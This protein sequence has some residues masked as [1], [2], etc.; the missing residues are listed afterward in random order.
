MR[1]LGFALLVCFPGALHAQS[2]AQPCRAPTL[3]GGYFVPRQEM[4]S[5]KTKLTYAC[6]TGR[7]PVVEGWWVT[8][9]CDNG[10]WSHLPQCIDENACIPPTI[11][12]GKYTESSDG[13]YEN[14]DIIRITCDKG[15]EHKDNDATGICTN[16]NWSSLPIC[17]RSMDACSEPPKVP[18]AVIIDLGYQKLFAGDSKVR[19]ECKD[20]YT[21]EG[22]HTKKSIYCLSG[23]W[24]EGPVCSKGR[25][26]GTDHGGSAAGGTSGGHTSSAGRGPSTNS[27]TAEGGIQFAPINRCR[28]HP[29]VPNG[30]ITE[31]TVMFLKYECNNF[32]QRVGPG[33]V[34][35]HSNG[36][37]SA[38]P[39]CRATFCTVDI[40][41]YPH[42]SPGG[43][44]FVK[45]GET[46][47]FECLKQSHWITDHFSMGSC[48]DGRISFDECCS[49]VSRKIGMC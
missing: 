44:K 24:S 41:Q 28:K 26:P 39:S 10:I 37:W 42:L 9:T 14:G 7:Q 36:M 16:G 25:V 30:V 46:E 32:Y 43:V 40:Q 31:I 29:V 6:D 13:W 3:A 35:C 49:W 47:K 18:H 27:G 2:A 15:Y 21:I 34:N 8:S 45:H 23:N 22:G 17:E 11:P 20:G 5:H 1:Y 38:V 19:Y 33:T 12:N 4:F 48:T